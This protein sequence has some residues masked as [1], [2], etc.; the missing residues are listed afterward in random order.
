MARLKPGVS[1]R[2]AQAGMQVL[3]SQVVDAV[4]DTAPEPGKGWY[5]CGY[6]A[7]SGTLSD[8][9]SGELPAGLIVRRCATSW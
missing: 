1:I 6:R 5:S 8:K 4:N 9:S 3:W 7:S 2:H